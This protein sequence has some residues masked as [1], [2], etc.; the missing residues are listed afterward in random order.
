MKIIDLYSQFTQ[1]FEKHKAF[2][3]EMT[4]DPE[5]SALFKMAQD[6][7]VGLLNVESWLKTPEYNHHRK[8]AEKFIERAPDVLSRVQDF[9]GDKLHGEIRLA[10]SFMQ[11]D[12]F[13]R[14]D[15]GNHTVW[16]GID[17]PD[18]DEDYLKVLMAHELSHV[19]RDHQPNVWGHTGVPLKNFTREMYLEA[20][21]AEEHLASEGLATLFSQ[22][23][24]P[25]VPLHIHHY[26]EPHEM[27]WCLENKSAI[28]KAM[29][30]CLNTD[31]NVWKFYG[32]DVI[33]P[34]SPSRTQYFW[35]AYQISEW[36]EAQQKSAAQEFLNRG[37][38]HDQKIIL[39][40]KLPAS[41]FDCF[42][43]Q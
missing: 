3:P 23:V 34:G 31:Q 24:Y 42:K 11:F 35:G 9:F 18:A 5:F 7:E 21:T 16:F 37:K 43:V 27:A 32:D 13:A 19:H 2:T 33:A 39:A 28:D 15:S 36:L 6:W 10:P 12:G 38:N 8:I 26:Y 1:A 41:D 4:A 20:V 30:Q 14:Y 25:E 40:H 22:V 29:R 17:H